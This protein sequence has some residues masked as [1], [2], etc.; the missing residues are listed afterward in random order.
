MIF[1]RRG[2]HPCGNELTPASVSNA[3]RNSN[4]DIGVVAGSTM[5]LAKLMI[6]A[7]ITATNNMSHNVPK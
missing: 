3:A 2:K 6:P 5:Y 1:A 4:G 7:T